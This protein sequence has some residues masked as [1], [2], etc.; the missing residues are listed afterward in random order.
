M[1]ESHQ[2]AVQRMRNSIKKL[3]SSVEWA[4]WRADFVPRGHIPDDEV[5][6]ELESKKIYLQGLSKN[7]YSLLIVLARKHFPSKDHLQFKKFVV[8][9][10]DKTIASSFSGEEKGDEKLVAI[11]DLESLTLQNIDPRALIT[12]FQFLQAY[13]P[14]RLARLYL[15]NMPWI[16]VSVWKMVSRFLEKA[17]LEKVVI[18]GNEEGKR[19]IL[20]DI[21][22]GT[23]PE[24]YGGRAKLTPLQDV[25]LSHWPLTA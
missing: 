19:T 15:L 2:I 1:E 25:K 22:E 16:F 14:E 11:L 12:G 7:G 6:Q 18:V 21:G 3:G 13:Y 4:K 23:L 5:L 24:E 9:L 20:E 8:H 17:T 10:L